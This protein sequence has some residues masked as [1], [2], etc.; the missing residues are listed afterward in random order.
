MVG[1]LAAVPVESAGNGLG[2]VPNADDIQAAKEGFAVTNIPT[3]DGYIE[4]Y[5]FDGGFELHSIVADLWSNLGLLGI[6]LGVTMAILIAASLADRIRRRS[7]SGLV[8]FL[9]ITSLWFLA[10]GTLWSNLL[11]VTFTVG[12]MLPLAARASSRAGASRLSPADEAA[13]EPAE[14]GPQPD[15]TARAGD[16]RYS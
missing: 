10:F 3:A 8:C 13:A 1:H 2:T 15:R 5:L 7:A 14:V 11:Q 4:N 16:R 12:L 9:A 6:A